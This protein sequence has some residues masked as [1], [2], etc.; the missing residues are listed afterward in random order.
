MFLP[1]RE[2]LDLSNI[3]Q[4]SS[5]PK[6]PA[7]FLALEQRTIP[8]GFCIIKQVIHSGRGRTTQM[9]DKMLA[10]SIRQFDYKI[11]R[12]REKKNLLRTANGKVC[13]RS[14][15]ICL[16]VVKFAVTRCWAVEVRW[17]WVTS[18]SNY[19]LLS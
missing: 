12:S 10:H 7:A 17:V 6:E 5:A 4:L 18:N 16:R 15:R 3:S 11:R 14:N 2:F 13:W 1:R 19:L 9:N 8:A